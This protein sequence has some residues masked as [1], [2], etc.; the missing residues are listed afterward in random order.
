MELLEWAI[1]AL[2]VAVGWGALGFSGAARP[3]AALANA[4]FGFFM[5]IA[6]LLMVLI[7]L[8]VGASG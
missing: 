6:V 5:A 8:G 3:A 1:G 2:I 4:L 7:V